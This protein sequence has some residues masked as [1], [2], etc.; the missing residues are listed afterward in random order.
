[1]DFPALQTTIDAGHPSTLAY[2]ADARLAAA[3]IMAPNIPRIKPAL[4]G[5]EVFRLATDDAEYLGLTADG[6]LEW[7]G[8]CRLETL[9]PADSG[10]PHQIVVS[11]FGN[12]SSTLFNWNVL[13]S[14]IVSQATVEK[15]GKVRAGDIE[16]IRGFRQGSDQTQRILDLAGGT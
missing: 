16:Y 6:R 12:P 14:E 2:N 3:E 8:L 9:D 4:T 13:R 1:M 11:I 7:L 5:D 10:L 15:L